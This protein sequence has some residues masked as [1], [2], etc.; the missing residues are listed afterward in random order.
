MGQSPSLAAWRPNDEQASR[1]LQFQD[2]AP[3]SMPPAPH[4]P[5]EITRALIAGYQSMGNPADAHLHSKVDRAYFPNDVPLRNAEHYLFS[6]AF[7]GAP[8]L[9]APAYLASKGMDMFQPGP[10]GEP[11]FDPSKQY[12]APD[13]IGQLKW[14]MLP[15][16]PRM[17]QPGGPTYTPPPQ[18][19]PIQ[20]PLQRGFDS[21]LP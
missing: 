5:D 1:L 19:A 4:T 21:R 10:L 9:A 2:Q 17:F 7:G 13:P 18:Q 16:L 6:N 15:I 3:T 11:V 12:S 14:G 20:F 8:G